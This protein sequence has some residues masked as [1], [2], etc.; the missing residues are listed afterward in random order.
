MPSSVNDIYKGGRKIRE[1]L[2]CTKGMD[3]VLPVT[4]E[5]A[6]AQIPTDLYNLLSF[7]LCGQNQPNEHDRRRIIEM[8]AKTS[9]MPTI[10]ET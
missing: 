6:L 10:E 3:D 8:L 5:Q 7:I 2:K 9:F 4:K 1:P